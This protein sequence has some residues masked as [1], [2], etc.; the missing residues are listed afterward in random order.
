MLY[1]LGKID[2][3]IYYFKS[4]GLQ[5]MHG[6]EICSAKPSSAKLDVPESV[7]TIWA[8]QRWPNMRIG[9]HPWYII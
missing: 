2:V 5:L 9:G 8:K 7:W 1:V 3:L 6:A 4:S